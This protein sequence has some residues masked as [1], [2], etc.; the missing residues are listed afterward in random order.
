MKLSPF[1][2]DK[3]YGIFFVI[4]HIFFSSMSTKLLK[5]VHG[6]KYHSFFIN[7][8][9]ISKTKYHNYLII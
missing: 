2:V 5:F 3:Y 9:A 8:G 6:N 1:E 4:L 7:I